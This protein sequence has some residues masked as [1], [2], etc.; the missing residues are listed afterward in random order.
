VRNLLRRSHPVAR[1]RF[2]QIVEFVVPGGVGVE[3]R[4]DGHEFPARVLDTEE[5]S[6][7]DRRY[8]IRRI[9]RSP[10]V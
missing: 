9:T 5:D 3:L 10:E 7:P 4:D 6:V 8:P 1:S 2:A